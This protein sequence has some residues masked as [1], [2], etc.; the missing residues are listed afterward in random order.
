MDG[1]QSRSAS[2][3]NFSFELSRGNAMES[4]V[5]TQ[6]E[7]SRMSKQGRRADQLD[8]RVT[9]ANGS[10]H[11]DDRLSCQHQF[12]ANVEG[13]FRRLGACAGNERTES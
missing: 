9:R 6:A 11:H 8:L 7:V 13:E 3:V 12:K 2:I 4:G 10:E 5:V 1:Q